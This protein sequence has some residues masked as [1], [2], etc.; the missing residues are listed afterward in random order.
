MLISQVALLNCFGLWFANCIPLGITAVRL[1]THDAPHRGKHRLGVMAASE[2]AGFES[3]QH[4]QIG[5]NCGTQYT[6][7]WGHLN[8]SKNEILEPVFFPGSDSARGV[9]GHQRQSF[10]GFGQ[11]DPFK[12]AAVC[13]CFQ[14][15]LQKHW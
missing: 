15:P 5:R 4:R 7:I 14:Q 11:F 3:Q 8:A 13:G 2:G 6:S 1:W 10:R 12:S 9:P